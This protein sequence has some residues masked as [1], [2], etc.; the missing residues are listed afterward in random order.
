MKYNNYNGVWFKSCYDIVD[1]AIS[2]TMTNE[3]KQQRAYIGLE[4]YINEYRTIML[5]LQRQC[6]KSTYIKEHAGLNDLVIFHNRDTMR[7]FANSSAD[8]IVFRDIINLD[9]EVF[10]RRY[11]TIWCDELPL[12]TLAGHGFKELI[13]NLTYK[14]AGEELIVALTSW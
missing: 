1:A 5:R 4:S 2:L 7:R 8:S 6:G 14:G 12:I 11:E 13:K 10:T 9:N 3:H